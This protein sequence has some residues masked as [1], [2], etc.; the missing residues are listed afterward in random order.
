MILLLFTI[1]S[2]ALQTFISFHQN[3][4]FLFKPILLF[5]FFTKKFYKMAVYKLEMSLNCLFL[6]DTFN[7][8]FKVNVG[9]K[10]RDDNN[11]EIKIN[12]FTITDL[13]L[14]IQC[15]K[16]NLNSSGSMSLLKVDLKDGIKLKYVSE[17]EHIKGNLGGRKMEP[18][19]KFRAKSNFPQDYKP[20]D[21][22]VHVVVTVPIM[23]S[24]CGLLLNSLF[25]YF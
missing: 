25:L 14:L 11:V 17:E 24:I 21:N 2:H 7:D 4:K 15:T 22:H 18:M 12:D 10:F 9:D 1:Y 20:S 6:G 5:Y 19:T 16:K 8:I 23:V 3:S 13:K